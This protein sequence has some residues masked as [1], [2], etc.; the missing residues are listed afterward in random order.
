MPQVLI[1]PFYLREAAGDAAGVAA[2]GVLQLAGTGRGIEVDGAAGGDVLAQLAQVFGQQGAE[3][4]QGPGTV[5]HGVEHLQGDAAAVVEE[6]NQPAV[7]LP[8]AHGAAEIRRVLSH[9][10][11]GGGIGLEVVPEKAPAYAH[12]KAGKRGMARS[13]ARCSAAG[14]T[15][16]SMKAEKRYMAE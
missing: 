15:S 1:R 12:G 5:G 10:G 8:E 4:H 13:T 7:V 16:R 2:V 6:A 11:A 14:S 3:E 9:K